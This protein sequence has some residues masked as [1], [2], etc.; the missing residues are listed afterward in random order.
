MATYKEAG[1]DIDA[2][3]QVIGK[4]RT[5]CPDIGGFGGL[6]PLGNQYLVAGTDGVGTKL[7]IALELDKHNTIGIDLVAMCVNDIITSGAKPLFFLDYYAT[8][9]LQPQRF[10]RVLGGIVEGCHEAGCALLGGETAEMPGFYPGG[11]YDLA[12][13]AV[14]IVE[15]EELVDGSTIKE[16][17]AIIGIASSGFHSNG[18][19][20]IRKVLA[21]R[22]LSWRDSVGE[23]LLEPTRI[24][25]NQVQDLLSRFKIKGMAHITGGG[26]IEN[27]PRALPSGIGAELQRWEI[28][29]LFTWLQELGSIEEEEMMRTFNMGIGFVVIVDSADVEELLALSSD[30]ILLG[31][32]ATGEGLRF[33]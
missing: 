5:I 25:V 33:K 11:Q 23:Q 14:G 7:K 27:L 21:D 4:L 9:Q 6:Y 15:K 22:K 1:V 32:T 8:G 20:L 30:Y 29:S 13:F 24:Y 12:G 17:D 10:E 16:G 26:I 18:Y 3:S 31:M 19:S 28:P 2:A